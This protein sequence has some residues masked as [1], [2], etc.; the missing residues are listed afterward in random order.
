M[1][2]YLSINLT[3]VA[4]MQDLCAEKPAENADEKNQRSIQ[5]KRH[6]MYMEWKT[7]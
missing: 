4:N 6:A 1:K 3:K 5:I 7:T 2:K